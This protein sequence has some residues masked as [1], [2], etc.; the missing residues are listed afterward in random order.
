MRPRI[1]SALALASLAS[2]ALVACGPPAPDTVFLH[3]VESGVTTAAEPPTSLAEGD[4]VLVDATPQ[5][6]D[7]P[8]EL[9]IDATVS[10]S[11]AVRVARVRGNCRRFA[12]LAQASGTA[13]VRF[14]ARGTA[15]V[16]VV[17][18]TPAR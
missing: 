10:G 2:V 14:E 13:T 5:D 11:T 9:C 3:T 17:N 18:V 6:G 16:L 7:D 1:E 8:M 15:S 4:L 12:V